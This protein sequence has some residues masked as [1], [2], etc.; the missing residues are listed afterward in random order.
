MFLKEVGV[1]RLRGE[2]TVLVVSAAKSAKER[3]YTAS[4]V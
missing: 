1:N 2:W 4:L 3:I